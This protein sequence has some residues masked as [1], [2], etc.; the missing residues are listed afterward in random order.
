MV[1]R[2]KKSLLFTLVLIFSLGQ[3]F[4]APVD[5]NMAQKIGERFIKS[6]MKSL[7]DFQKTEH[8]FTLSDDN[9]NACLYVFNIDDS[10]YFIVSADDRAKPIL[11]Y[12]EEGT[13]DIDNMPSSMSYYLEHYKNSISFVIENDIE[14]TE[15]IAKEWDLVS[16][17]GVVAEKGLGKSVDPLV[18]L[19]WNQDNPY[20]YY[21]PTAPGGPGGR[22]YVGC[23]ADAMAMLMK[24]WDYPDAGVGEHSYF[25]PGFPEQSITLGEEYD[26]DNMPIQINAGSQQNQIH[27]IATL[28]YHCGVTINMEYGAQGSAAYSEVVPEAMSSH[29]KYTDEMKHEYRDYYT[30][31]QWED[32]L[33]SNFDQGFPVFYAGHSDASGGHAFICDGYDDNRYIH[34]NWGWS[35][36]ANGYFSVDAVNPPGYNF[37]SGQRAIIDFLPDYVYNNMIPEAEIESE[38]DNA[39]SHKGII[40]VVV[41]TESITGEAL[42]KIDEMVLMRNNTIIQTIS[43]PTPGEVIYFEDEVTDYDCYTYTVYGVNDGVK[44][45]FSNIK[46]QY[47][48]TCSWKIICTTT[49]FQGWNGGKIQFV[50]S[51]GSVFKEVTMTSSSPI[52]ELVSMPEG[53][54]TMKWVA[55]QSPVNTLSIRLKDSSNEEVYEYSGTSSDLS[56]DVIFSA[57]NS[58]VGCESPENIQGEYAMQDGNFGALISW[59]N[60]GEPQSFKVYR[61]EDGIDY[62]E[63]AEVDPSEHQYFDPSN[64]VGAYYYQVTSYNSYCESL[65]AM[66]ANGDVD[67]VLVDITSLEENSS[68]AMIYPNPTSSVVNVKVEGILSVSIYNNVGQLLMSDN[69]D[70]DEYMVDMS[71]L[72][73]GVYMIRINTRNGEIKKQITV[74]D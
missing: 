52:S 29:F 19:L 49:N 38:S 58:C 68:D 13:L 21:C 47:G 72:N 4:A 31:T 6:N 15:E 23:A 28:M 54:F 57:E 17:E 16:S 36:F 32:M 35:G 22:A 66:N 1:S 48:P 41:P 56:A 10:G 69:V 8:V 42:S 33:I 27:A 63:V 51:F 5:V 43:N 55:P 73:N 11:A 34:F 40:K 50:N 12:S 62:E 20:N 65:P 25:P 59:E 39:Y 53:N 37:S 18:N 7:R 2:M 71:T 64:M 26:W 61:S 44:G 9:G 60:G 14:A 24:Y 3:M 70:A 74:I 46:L 30:K 45:R 67:Y